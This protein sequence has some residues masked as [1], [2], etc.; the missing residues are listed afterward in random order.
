MGEAFIGGVVHDP[1]CNASVTFGDKSPICF[2][3][4]EWKWLDALAQQVG[5]FAQLIAD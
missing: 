5:D 4:V 3:A 2:K 1:V